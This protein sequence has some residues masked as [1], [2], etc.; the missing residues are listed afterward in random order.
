MRY[1]ARSSTPTMTSS[2]IKPAAHADPLDPGGSPPAGLA[3]STV[4]GR[5]QLAP[6]RHAQNATPTDD[7][8]SGTKTILNTNTKTFI[9]LSHRNRYDKKT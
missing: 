5:V 6:A 7:R 1:M 4:P 2:A 8:L 3:A 9:I